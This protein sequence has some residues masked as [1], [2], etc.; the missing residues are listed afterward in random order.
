M[1]TPSFST[2]SR[3]SAQVCPTVE[4]KTFFP[5]F[6]RE[7]MFPGAEGRRRKLLHSLEGIN[8]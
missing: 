5:W 6:F 1:G 3:A 7:M 8:Q 2:P 4:R